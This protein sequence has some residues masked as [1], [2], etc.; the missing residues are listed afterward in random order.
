MFPAWTP[1]DIL[2]VTGTG[3]IDFGFAECS[4]QIRVSE[5]D[6]VSSRGV[7]FNVDAPTYIENGGS[8]TDDYA[9]F[10]AWY[11]YGST[12]CA[13]PPKIRIQYAN[14]L[15]AFSVDYV[16]LACERVPASI[17]VQGPTD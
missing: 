5:D 13:A 11:L 3:A 16:T 10:V 14:I 6:W 2:R 9:S 7:G 12:A 8:P 15:S 4:F 17:Y 1:G